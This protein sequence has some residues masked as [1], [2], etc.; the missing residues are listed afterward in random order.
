[1]PDQNFGGI[2]ILGHA[3]A[4]LALADAGRHAEKRTGRQG[5]DELASGLA[6][7][8]K[9]LKCCRIGERGQR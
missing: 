4:F 3:S 2:P 6:Q 7:A 9:Y 1:V 8:D 5:C